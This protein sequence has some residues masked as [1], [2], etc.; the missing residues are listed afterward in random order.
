MRRFGFLWPANHRHARF[1]ELP[2]PNSKFGGVIKDSA[3][4]SKA[5]CA[6]HVVPL[7]GAPNV[8]LALR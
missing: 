7:T 6:P 5:C 4:R 2:A 1:T 3:A 8:L